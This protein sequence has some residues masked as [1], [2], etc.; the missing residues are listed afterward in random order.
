M[1]FRKL[2]KLA[3]GDRVGVVSPSFTAPAVFPQI[4]ELGLSRMQNVFALDPVELPSNRKIDASL[5]DRASDLVEAFRNPQLKAIFA[6]IGGDHQVMYV[7]KMEKACFESNPKPFFGFSDNT[8]FCNFLW[9]S[10][11][12]SY[13]GASILC[14]FG[15]QGSMD[16]YTV[17]YL[18][19]ALFNEGVVEIVSSHEFNDQGL[20][21]GDPTTLNKTR[22]YQPNEGWYWDGK[23]DASGITWGGCLESIDDML[24][25]D[26]PIPTLEQFKS[27]ILFFETSEELPSAIYVSRVLRALGERGILGNVQGVVV[28]RPKAWE[29]D[30]QKSDTDKDQF[31]SAQRAAVLATFRKYNTH[32]PLVQNLDFGHTDPQF[33]MPVGRTMTI[34]STKR[35]IFV[36]F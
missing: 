35:K 24:R 9:L 29:F 5:A 13:Y 25:H 26:V 20:D 1:Y 7:H 17:N 2:K 18:K 34:N 12:P 8:H 6:T 14:Q 31:K 27:V 32:A 23:Q 4:Y 3:P 30:N 19:H 10:G 36:E 11:V 16:A 33:P 22:R 28:G 21:W 15:M